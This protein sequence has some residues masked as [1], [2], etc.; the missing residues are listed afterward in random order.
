MEKANSR[1]NIVV[2][3]ISLWFWFF[4]LSLLF[5]FFT[6]KQYDI[7]SLRLVEESVS[8][9][10]RIKWWVGSWSRDRLWL[11]LWAGT[12][13]FVIIVNTAIGIYSSWVSS[14]SNHHL[15]L[16]LLQPDDVYK[17]A[18][19]EVRGASK[20]RGGGARPREG[21]SFPIVMLVMLI[22]IGHQGPS[23]DCF[24]RFMRP[25]GSRVNKKTVFDRIV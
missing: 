22:V 20:S 15:L 10:A 19:A 7:Y 13:L 18:G 17:P 9:K 4:P 6:F 14:P 25:R 16:L 1:Y 2:T 3:L 5:S 23:S 8:D 24:G 12:A 21:R 11:W